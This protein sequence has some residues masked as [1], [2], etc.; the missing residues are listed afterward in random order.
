MLRALGL[1]PAAP[2]LAKVSADKTIAD[3][4]GISPANVAT[5][6]PPPLSDTPDVQ[7]QSVRH[8]KQKI[9]RFLTNRTLPYWFEEEVRL[10]NRNVSFLD[11]DIANKRSWSMAVKIVTQ[12][13]RNIADAKRNALEGPRRSMRMREF[14]NEWGFWI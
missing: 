11:P 1:A 7:T 10:R 4:V 12:R 5:Y 8:W 3:L 9:I 6:H 14:E 2:I 13:E